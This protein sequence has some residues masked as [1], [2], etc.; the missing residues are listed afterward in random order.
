MSVLGPDDPRA[1]RDPKRL[2]EMREYTD[3]FNDKVLGLK[4]RRHTDVDDILAML[5]DSAVDD[6]VPPNYGPEE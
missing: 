2:K 6:D 4:P 1:I 5:V 3:E